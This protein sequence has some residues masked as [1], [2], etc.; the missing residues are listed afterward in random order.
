[1]TKTLFVAKGVPSGRQTVASTDLRRTL[2]EL[3][4]T[5]WP[6]GRVVVVQDSGIVAADG[7][8]EQ[9]IADNRNVALAIL[10]T[11]QVTVERMKHTLASCGTGVSLASGPTRTPGTSRESSRDPILQQVLKILCADTLGQ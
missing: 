9:P 7:S 10:K 5:A 11:L 4:V 2:L 6:Y 3:P 1:M 8:D